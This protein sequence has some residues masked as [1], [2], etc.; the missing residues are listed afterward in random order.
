MIEKGGKTE[1]ESD[2][3]GDKERRVER[4]NEKGISVS[5][6]VCVV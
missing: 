3:G 2:E 1:E 5:L 6:C 4:T